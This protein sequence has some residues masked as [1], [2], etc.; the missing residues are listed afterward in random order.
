MDKKLGLS[1]MNG[2][3]ENDDK[4]CAITDMNCVDGEAETKTASLQDMNNMTGED[5]KTCGITDMNC[6]GE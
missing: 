1:N 6:L 3:T 2:V 5:D 4:T